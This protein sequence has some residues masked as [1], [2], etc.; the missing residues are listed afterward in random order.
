MA[1][2]LKALALAGALAL[3]AAPAGIAGSG[4][5]SDPRGDTWGDPSGGAGPVDFVRATY[6]HAKNGN[7]V[8]KVTVAGNVANPASGSGNVPMLWIED[9]QDPNGHADCRYFIGRHEGR[10]GV[11]TCGYGDRVASARIKRTSSNTIRYEFS[12]GAIGNP[13]SYGWAALVMAPAD[14]TAL[15]ADRLPDGDHS[16]LTHK[17]R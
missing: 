1:K 14:G 13:P 8:H 3:A 2:A 4:S 5:A 17:L 16:F 12:P 15:W 6:G 7:L 10:L 9:P 11:F